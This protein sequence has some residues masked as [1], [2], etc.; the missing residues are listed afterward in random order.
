MGTDP[1]QNAWQGQVFHDYLQSF[2]VFTFTHHLNI[3]LDIQPGRTGQSTRCLVGLLNGKSAGDRLGVSFISGLAV[4]KALI[5][6]IREGDRTDFGTIAAGSTLVRVNIAGFLMKGDLK[7]SLRAFK[8]FNFR[9]RDQVDVQMPADLDQFRRDNSHRTI[10]SG[11]GFIQFTHDTTDGRGLLD[12]VN[13]V[14]G[15]GQIQGG[16]HAGNSGTHNHHGSIDLT[17]F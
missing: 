12:Q 1:A 7:I 14:S 16:L 2:L 17:L 3:G 4:T 13:Q 11:K 9:T 10:I 6:F 15:I 8:C 5:I